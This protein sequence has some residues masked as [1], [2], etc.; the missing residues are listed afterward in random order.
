VAALRKASAEVGREH[1]LHI[2]VTPER[3]VDAATAAE[4]AEAGAD[5]LVI[6]LRSDGD[7]ESLHRMLERT[8]PAALGATA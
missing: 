7:P 1:P 4:Y 3:Q 8:A 6:A 5:R 2:S